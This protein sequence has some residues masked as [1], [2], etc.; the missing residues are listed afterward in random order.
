METMKRKMIRLFGSRYHPDEDDRGVL[1]MT[2]SE[3][4]LSPAP[5][6]RPTGGGTTLLGDGEKSEAE[7]VVSVGAGDVAGLGMDSLYGG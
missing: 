2:S 4:I 1:V 5:F 3:E 6:P 7:C